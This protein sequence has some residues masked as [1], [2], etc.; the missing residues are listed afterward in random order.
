M[1]IKERGPNGT[2]RKVDGCKA[3]RRP[4][5]KRWCSH[6]ISPNKEFRTPPEKRKDLV[7]FRHHIHDEKLRGH[8][9][10]HPDKV[11]SVSM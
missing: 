9:M 8:E 11:L 3:P 10:Q 7:C 6:G 5:P 2:S 1:E 4:C